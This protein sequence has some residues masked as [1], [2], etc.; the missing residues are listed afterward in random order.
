MNG[1]VIRVVS[2]KGVERSIKF[3]R[4]EKTGAIDTAGGF[5]AQIFLTLQ[6][7]HRF[8]YVIDLLPSFSQLASKLHTNQADFTFEFGVIPERQKVLHFLPVIAYSSLVFFTKQPSHATDWSLIRR[9]FDSSLW[10]GVGIAAI[11]VLTTHFFLSYWYSGTCLQS[12]RKVDYVLCPLVEQSI[13][14]FTWRQRNAVKCVTIAWIFTALILCTGYKAKLTNLRAQIL[15]EDIPATFEQLAE[16]DY[17]IYLHYLGG[18]F[19]RILNKSTN[20]VIQKIAVRVKPEKSLYSCFQFALRGRA[21]CISMDLNGVYNAY[22]NFSDIN[23]QLLL[24]RS[25]D[26]SNLILGAGATRKDAV[27]GAEFSKTVRNLLDMG[28]VSR[29]QDEEDRLE[30]RT[31]KFW[32]RERLTA[33]LWRHAKEDDGPRAITVKEFL[34]LIITAGAVAVAS[35]FILVIERMH[36]IMSHFRALVVAFDTNF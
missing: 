20:P 14:S 10:I 23:G 16:S 31:G 21:A 26:R 24:R 11:V 2:C 32:A 28:L 4:E 8:E 5:A 25:A 9:P 27:F 17:E 29:Y 7:K 6:E 19:Q 34:V 18:F 35:A 1:S 30:R 13:H 22:S 12:R 36:S 33:E 15:D 3:R